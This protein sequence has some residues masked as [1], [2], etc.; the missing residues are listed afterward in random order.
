MSPCRKDIARPCIASRLALLLTAA[1]LL[2]LASPR[3]H[4]L[5]DPSLQCCSGADDAGSPT[6]GGD[7]VA[8]LG[9]DSGTSLGAGNP[10]N[11]L[12]GNK[13][14]RE[15]DMAA[16]PG[17]LGLEL[18]RYYNSS[19]P[20]LG[21]VGR[22][23]RLSYESE[24]HLRGDELEIVQ[25]DGARLG[26]KR[27]VQHPDTYLPRLPSQGRVR[28]Q[29]QPDAT[30][31]I[32]TWADGRALRFNSLGQLASIRVP[33]GEV[34]HIHYDDKGRLQ[35]VVDPAGRSLQLRYLDPAMARYGDRFRG[36]QA[37]DTPFGRFDYEY[38]S[39]LPEGS[40]VDP[41]TLLANL[42]AVHYPTHPEPRRDQP[43]E[44]EPRRGMLAL[45]QEP[46]PDDP[47]RITRRYHYENPRLPTLLTGISLEDRDGDGQRRSRR[48]NTW[49]Y[50]AQGR[51]I[52]GV[53]GEQPAQG[54]EAKPGARGESARRGASERLTLQRLPPKQGQG[55]ILLTNSLGQQTTYTHTLIAGQPRL[56]EARGPGCASCSPGNVRYGYDQLGRLTE[57]TTLDDHGRPQLTRRSELDR[58]G[59]P[60]RISTFKWRDG[61]PQPSQWQVRYEYAAFDEDTELPSSRPMLIARPSVIAGQEYRLHVRYNERGQRIEV[62]ETG[63]S[64]I[65]EQHHP[66]P[67]GQPIRRSTTYSY[68]EVNG[69]S[70]LMS[71]DGPLPNGPRGDPSDSDITRIEWDAR[72]DHIVAVQRPGGRRIDV[73]PDE[74]GGQASALASDG[75][76]RQQLQLERDSEAVA[77]PRPDLTLD[78]SESVQPPKTAA[79]PKGAGVSPIAAATT[80]QDT[81]G[82][83]VAWFDRRGAKRLQLGWGGPGS[84]AQS[85]LLSISTTSAQ[86]LRQV[87]DW[88]RVV[89][90]K[91]PAQGWQTAR[92]DAA[93]HVLEV[94]D[95][96]GARQL[97]Q[98]D[99]AGRLRLLQRYAPKQSK[100]E[101]TLSWRYA[102]PWASEETIADADGVRSIRTERNSRGQVLKQSL[103]LRPAGALS[104]TLEP[105]EMSVAY[106]YDE[107]GRLLQRRFTDGQGRTVQVQQTINE[108]GQPEALSTA[109]WLPRWLGGGERRF[110]QQVKWQSLPGLPALYWATDIEHVDGSV[111]RYGSVPPQAPSRGPVLPPEAAPWSAQA[112]ARPDSAALR[113]TNASG[114]INAMGVNGPTA[115]SVPGRGADAAGLPAE[116]DTDQGPQRLRWNAAAQLQQSDRADGS[117]SRYLYDARGRRIVKLITDAQGHSTATLSFYEDSRLLA[118]ADAQGRAMFAYAYLGWRPVAQLRLDTNGWQAFRASLFGPEAR[119]LHT[120]RAGLVQ[121]MTEQGRTVWQ[122]PSRQGLLRLANASAEAHQPLRYVGQ[123]HDDDSGLDYHGA[124]Y[125]EAGI[126]RFISPDPQGVADAVDSVVP[127]ALLDLYAYAGGQPEAFFDPDGAARMRYFAITTGANGKALG[128]SQG[129]TKA[130]WAFIVDEVQAPLIPSGNAVL[131][132]LQRRYARDETGLLFDANGNFLPAGQS[133]ATWDGALD[134]TQDRFMEQYGNTLISIP[135]FTVQMS[136]ADAARLIASYIT[137]DR[138]RLYTDR[139]P[140]GSLFLP[141]IRFAPEE[142]QI[143]VTFNTSG[144]ADKQRIVACG[145]G[146][147]NDLDQR[148]VSKYEAA[149]EINETGR[150]NRDC[151]KDGCP[152]IGYYC[153]S[154]KC[155]SPKDQLNYGPPTTNEP[156]YTPSFGRSQF[157]G[158][159]LVGHLLGAYGTFS[160]DDLNQLG[161]NA[162]IKPT[163]AAAQ[164][165]GAK[166]AEWWKD[167]RPSTDYASAN[168]AWSE[169]SAA[170]RARFTAETGLGERVYTDMI[171][172]K[173]QPPKNSAGDDLSADA[174][175]A[176][177]TAAI[178]SD[179]TTRDYLMGVFKDFDKFTIMGRGLMKENLNNARRY[180]PNA[181]EAYLAAMVARAHNGG[182][183]MKTYEQLVSRDEHDYVK[184]FVGASGYR[185]KGDWN[186]LR[187]AEGFG[188]RTVIPGTNGEGIGGLEMAPLK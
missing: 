50:D 178:M 156:V 166:M 188:S 87:D 5:C 45:Y 14:Q 152:G 31:Y 96:R 86:A 108:Q 148:R 159:T 126:G 1:A 175:Q 29:R 76:H 19:E 4:A 69:R 185:R 164:K 137:A 136:D 121:G 171:R 21:W 118:E 106:A 60:V 47:Q 22:G 57:Q 186:A 33:S 140:V 103:L 23:W 162:A 128:T 46:K 81:F 56:L 70:L 160:T 114:S 131:D 92:Y 28:A 99:L 168:A 73:T 139:C 66:A 53:R 123:V 11:L 37:I 32:W 42:V 187:C 24:L 8:S 98:W 155:Y 78:G 183:W 105:I 163:L 122:H 125:Y 117:R 158:S 13:F 129:F 95:P 44:P 180:R 173:T 67:Q 115:W 179:S 64:P 146:S 151:S 35:Q 49:A 20:R 79:G 142:A 55:Q 77:G 52:L 124:R 17:V 61:R 116:I 176:L 177:V 36:V 135:Q 113:T 41:N 18:V 71:I 6:C 16:L 25:A 107:Q 83:P 65:D 91:N 182:T 7:G 101:Q 149:A 54:S 138:E 94:R 43:S 150:I 39:K 169:L 74:A 90:I 2:G 184:N 85:T 34:V 75:V 127:Q 111:D 48:L 147:D 51:A 120:D 84:V 10:I 161:L 172:I 40:T 134:N 58:W 141:P 145:V 119:A 170:D 68:A 30:H 97:V 38:G 110:V 26:F 88:G 153:D 59:R 112:A 133:A 165:R 174:A 143:L 102:G 93:D 154:T 100:P 157:I 144:D 104:A 181:S 63:F 9:N 15:V 82:R 130:R 62:T 12:N 167:S 80:E 89:A 27:S 72:G 132:D 3:A 109:G